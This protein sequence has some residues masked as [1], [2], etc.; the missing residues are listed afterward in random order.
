MLDIP[1]RGIEM[2]AKIEF[3]RWKNV[4]DVVNTAEEIGKIADKYLQ[5]ASSNKS[6]DKAQAR[7]TWGQLS[8]KYWD[9]LFA[10]LDAQ[11]ESFP[12][13]LTFDEEERLFI[14]FGF[15]HDEITPRNKKFDASLALTSKFALG[16]FSYRAFS[17]F[18]ADCWGMITRNPL[19]VSPSGEKTED[20]IEELE[21]RL[22]AL[23]EK[24][25]SEILKIVSRSKN[26][27]GTDLDALV[28]DMSRTLISATKASMR[29]KEYREAKD[30]LKQAMSQDRFRYNEAERVM[31]TQ[32]SIAQKDEEEPLGLPELEMFTAL[33]EST[34]ILARKII[35]CRQESDKIRRKAEKISHACAQFSQQMMRKELKN[36]LT[37]KKEYMAVPAKVARCEQSLL[38]PHDSEPMLYE[39]ASRI[40]E[41]MSDLD[42]DMFGVPRI[43]MYGVPQVIFIPGQGLGTYDWAD[44]TI[45]LPVFPTTSAEKA[46]A[47]G[48]GTF[49]WD[50]DEDRILKNAY[51]TIKD[52]KGKSIL[53]MAT[54]FYKDYFLWITKEKKGYRILPR[55]THK[56]FLQ[57]FAP[58]KQE[59]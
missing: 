25:N 24:R 56:T 17:D 27:T 5:Y 49:R 12:S 41:E 16:V 6:E 48:A 18:I 37:K 8:D 50:S 22:S 58:R 21:K 4:P 42:M 40:M 32:L 20:K 47:Y 35:Y 15:L 30:D 43:R 52:N 36:M 39:T 23:Q 10:I 28:S 53:E 46:I 9:L 29:T 59:D 3:K 26:M 38:C 33:H 19:P 51:E 34:K 31:E 54:S 7:K 2:A 11:T 55:D 1:L 57:M 13:A 45:L 44:H 14:D